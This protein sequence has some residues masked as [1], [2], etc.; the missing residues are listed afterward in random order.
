M[1]EHSE[2]FMKTVLLDWPI[3]Y[4]TGYPSV[5]ASYLLIAQWLNRTLQDYRS[6]KDLQIVFNTVRAFADRLQERFSEEE[7]EWERCVAA[8]SDIKDQKEE[9]LKLLRFLRHFSID[10]PVSDHLFTDIAFFVSSWTIQH[11]LRCDRPLAQR[12]KFSEPLYRKHKEEYPSPI[13]ERAIGDGMDGWL[14]KRY[15]EFFRLVLSQARETRFRMEHEREIALAAIPGPAIIVEHMEGNVL[16]ANLQT[17]N[18]LGIPIE[19]L[20]GFPFLELFTPENRE[21]LKNRLLGLV[22]EKRDLD[23]FETEMNPRQGDPIPVQLSVKKIPSESPFFLA[24]FQDIRWRKRIETSVREREARSRRLREAIVALSLREMFDGEELT[25]TLRRITR[26]LSEALSVG[27]AGI[28]FFSEDRATLRCSCMFDSNSNRFSEGEAIQ[29]QDFPSYF[30]ALTAERYIFANDVRSDPRTGQLGDTY[31][32][33]RGISSMLDAGIVQNGILIGVVCLEHT[34]HARKWHIDEMAFASSASSLIAQILSD[35]ER[36]NAEKALR[37]SEERYREML[38]LT[39]VGIIVCRKGIVSFINPSGLTLLK[40]ASKEQTIGKPIGDLFA[41]SSLEGY[42]QSLQE[43]N[44][45]D[46]GAPIRQSFLKR[47]DQ[48]VIEVEIVGAR[49]IEKTFPS[50]LLL[51]TDLSERKQA[52]K[53]R[54]ARQVAEASNRAKSVFLS[55]MSHE[56]RTPLNA[57]LGFSQLLSHEA[58]LPDKQRGFVQTIIQNGERLLKL[59]NNV[60]ELSRIDTEKLK[61]TLLEFDLHQLL[62]DL[63]NMFLFRSEEKGLQFILKIQPDVPRHIVGDEGKL[64]SVFV[65]LLGNAVKFTQ[66]GKVDLSI[67]TAQKQNRTE[68]EARPDI[69]YLEARIEDTGLGIPESDLPFLFES[70]PTTIKGSALERTGLGLTLTKR[71]IELMGGTISAQSAVNSGSVFVFQIPVQLAANNSSTTTRRGN[72]IPAAIGSLERTHIET[73]LE[74][75]P[76]DLYRRMREVLERGERLRFIALLTE[77]EAFDRPTGKALRALAQRYDFAELNALFRLRE[78]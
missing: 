11:F 29:K 8:A 5:D 15:E 54:I 60:L 78:D 19:T 56:I 62:E 52:E 51:I 47:F 33:A 45:F 34:G 59:V 41:D 23:L 38:N 18:L 2:P 28:W 49:S 12:V 21:P 66:S 37:E 63:K 4:E 77:V 68:K 22:A 42:L 53:D 50:V 76:A 16:K 64:R 20:F 30:E 35:I 72:P 55:H 44:S 31:L 3:D 74:K 36:K 13:K 69:V 7:G 10:T 57:I 14:L 73:G 26:I 75:L 58:S 67:G 6:G 61:V 17:A 70:Y 48:S 1:A 24:L 71:L 32:N 43:P 9:H 27:Q 39:P 25:Q 40:S 65:H 46:V